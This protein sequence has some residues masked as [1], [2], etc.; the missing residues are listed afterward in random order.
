MIAK[1]VGIFSS[2]LDPRKVRIAFVDH[3][4]MSWWV[5]APQVLK[6]L[7]LGNL[8]QT[9]MTLSSDPA[10]AI[11]MGIITREVY[12]EALAARDQARAE[13]TISPGDRVM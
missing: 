5:D 1:I 12:E 4:E 7:D 9:M 13:R 2:P 8:L 11:E 6:V 10:K 3:Q